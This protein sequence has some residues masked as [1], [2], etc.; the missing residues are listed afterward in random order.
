MLPYHPAMKIAT[1]LMALA[2]SGA[3]AAWPQFGR[4]S[5]HSGSA[6]VTAQPLRLM[7]A[8]IV[9]DPFA[10]QE[11]SMSGGSLLTHYAA[12]LIDGNDVFVEV[13]SGSFTANW[14][15]QS[16]TVQALRWNGNQLAARWIVASDW[17]PVPPAVNGTGP[18][19]EPV[20]QPVLAS[21]SIYMPGFGG[22]I[23][24]VN[25]DTGQILERLGATP[26]LDADTYVSGPLVVDS[27]GNIAYNVI[28]LTPGSPWTSDIRDAWLTRVTASG[29]S[30]TVRYSAITAGA[31]AATALCLDAFSDG[32]L[33]WPPSPSAVPPSVPCGS[34]RPGVNVA[35]A[36]ATDGTIYTVSRA[37]FNSRWSYMVAINPDL[38]PK[39]ITS[40]RDRFNDGCGVLL[41]PSGTPGGCQS[42]AIAGVDPADNT[43][44]A[45]RVVDESSSSPAVGPDG[46][47]FYGAYT[48]Y[49]YAQGH[50][51]QFSPS[52]V[53]LRAYRFGWDITPAIYPHDGTYSVVTKENHY[54]EPGSY[55]D[56]PSICPEVRQS[57]DPPGYF[58]VQ[59][60]SSLH[61]E[62]IAGNPNGREWCV[63]GPAIDNRGVIYVNS[64]DGFLYAFDGSGKIRETILLLATG[65]QAYTPM[66]IDD[67]GRVYA[68]SAGQLFVVG[69][70]LRHRAVRR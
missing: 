38:S 27:G 67:A 52:G 30:M 19:F 4:D 17:K 63:N 68:E 62:W 25:R 31:P 44:G 32:E 43:R 41:P 33:P 64:E 1:V 7:L 28:A 54:S 10:A 48:R 40:M 34:Q 23:L 9:M 18:K 46:S 47:V 69:V 50:M 5:G 59:L 3:F 15:T 14:Q 39:W 53:F 8:Q 42:G 24:R 26:P 37:H 58:I 16:W 2:A 13:K 49:N 65:G 55:C 11:I 21:N 20:F 36:I 70:P 22:S 60:D 12:P 29:Q 45:G 61:R 66:A 6:P 56:Y 57:D 35:P 51:M